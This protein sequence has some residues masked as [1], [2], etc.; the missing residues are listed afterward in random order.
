MDSVCI[1]NRERQGLKI[2]VRSLLSGLQIKEGLENAEKAKPYVYLPGEVTK[3]SEGYSLFIRRKIS[4]KEYLKSEEI[5]KD[6]IYGIISSLKSLWDISVRENLSFYNFLFDYDA[7]FPSDSYN[8]EF[9][10]LPGAKLNRENNSVKDML[11]LLLMHCSDNE[12]SL[13]DYLKEIVLKIAEWEEQGGDFP[14]V[15]IDFESVK[16]VFS[17]WRNM[18]LSSS[19]VFTIAIWMLITTRKIVLWPLWTIV[20]VIIIFYTSPLNKRKIS[21]EKLCYLENGPAFKNG[22]IT[23]GR[24]SGWADFCIRNLMI[25]RRHAV[26]VNKGS[27]LS[28]RDLF[29]SNGTY[30]DGCPLKPGEEMSVNPGQEVNF[31]KQCSFYVKYKTKFVLK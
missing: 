23:V 20:S 29:S 28:V 30:V 6:M 5:D 24:D 22:E 9:V 17:K 11:L 25:S 10:Y 12:D 8:M 21:I 2:S 31:G 14:E 3:D 13:T 27:V 7:I 15:T 16:G 19:G 18:I 26:V 4:V 1:L